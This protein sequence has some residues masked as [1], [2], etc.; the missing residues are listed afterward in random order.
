MSRNSVLLPTCHVILCCCRQ[1]KD[2]LIASLK[3]G[4]SGGGSQVA[5]S[6]AELDDMR[7]ERDILREELQQS[8]M[9]I[10]NLRVELQV[11]PLAGEV[12]TPAS[13]NRKLVNDSK[14]QCLVK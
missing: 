7:Q 10:E 14:W 8:R 13:G 11:I 12:K 9:T 5:V 6:P 2:R 3:E 1:S 4:V